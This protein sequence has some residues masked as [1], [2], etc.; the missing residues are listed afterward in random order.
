MRKK[1]FI[2]EACKEGTHSNCP[3]GR[4]CDCAHKVGTNGTNR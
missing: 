3:G 1:P 4:S 2:C